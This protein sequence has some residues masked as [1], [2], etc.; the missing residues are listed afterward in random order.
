[1]KIKLLILLSALALSACWITNAKSKK[2]AIGNGGSYIKMQEA[3]TQ[4][5]LPGIQGSE[6]YTETH[7]LLNWSDKNPPEAFY[8]RSEAGTWASCRVAKATKLAKEND[9]GIDYTIEDIK[10]NNIKKGDLIEVVP[11]SGGKHTLPAG[12][13]HNTINTLYFKTLKSNWLAFPV[14]ELMRKRDIAMP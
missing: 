4:T 7:F 8:W 13:P 3:Y 11:V 14:K 5:T 9:W 1:M 2:S 6:P 10:L 12:I